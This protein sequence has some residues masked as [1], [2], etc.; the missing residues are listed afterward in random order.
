[1]PTVRRHGSSLL[2][3]ESGRGHPQFSIASLVAAISVLAGVFAIRAAGL[4]RGPFEAGWP[5]YSC[6]FVIGVALI[7]APPW[8]SYRKFLHA[9]AH[10]FWAYCLAFIAINVFLM[11]YLPGETAMGPFMV[12]FPAMIAFVVSLLLW[13]CLR[14]FLP[15]STKYPPLKIAPVYVVIS[16]GWIWLVI[17]VW[18]DADWW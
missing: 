13:I 2:T 15:V 6:L 10:V 17:I 1:M 9:V 8:H 16:L 11:F 4:D 18:F 3:L 14:R 7:V 12:T 5:T